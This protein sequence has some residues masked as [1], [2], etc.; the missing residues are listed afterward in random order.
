MKYG[1]VAFHLMI[2]FKYLEQAS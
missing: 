2:F 1:L